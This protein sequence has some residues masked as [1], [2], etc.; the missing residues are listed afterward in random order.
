V[1]DDEASRISEIVADPHAASPSDHIVRETDNQLLREVL[2]TLSERESAILAMRF[3]LNDESPKTLEEVGEHFGLTRER[4]RQIQEE[5]LKKLR[6]EMEDRDSPSDPDIE[7]FV[8][9]AA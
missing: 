7:A 4:I 8:A 3:G 1:G 2:A 5:A 9:A 6:E